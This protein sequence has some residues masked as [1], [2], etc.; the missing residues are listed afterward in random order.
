MKSKTGKT[1]NSVTATVVLHQQLCVEPHGGAVRHYWYLTTN[2]AAENNVFFCLLC[3]FINIRVWFTALTQALANWTGSKLSQT[4]WNRCPG[5]RQLITVR[6]CPIVSDTAPTH[7]FYCRTWGF[8]AVRWAS[9][10][11][12]LMLCWRFESNNVVLRSC[13]CVNQLSLVFQTKLWYFPTSHTEVFL[14]FAWF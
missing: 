6:H 12:G 4:G 3:Y 7:L 8:N 14:Y 9:K 11:F 13:G 1:G 5:E 2:K 10:H